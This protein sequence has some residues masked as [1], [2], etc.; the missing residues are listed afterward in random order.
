MRASGPAMPRARV[1][2]RMGVPGARISHADGS[3]HR[4][5]STGSNALA[6]QC[7]AAGLPEPVLEY[8]FAPPRRWRFDLAWPAHKAAVEVDGGTWIGGRHSR[9]TGYERDAEKL[10]E[11]ALLGWLVIRVTPALVTDGRALRLVERALA[12][13]ET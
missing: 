3:T 12:L 7:S 8:R 2:R 9:G 4:V 10:N 5:S 11:A 13:Q 6:W 1:D